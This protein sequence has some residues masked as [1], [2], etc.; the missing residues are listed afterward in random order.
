M[1]SSSYRESMRLAMEQNLR[2][3]A[4]PLVSSGVYG[5]PKDQAL[6]VAVETLSAMAEES[7]MDVLMVL[8]DE[9]GVEL[10]REHYP[11]LV[12]LL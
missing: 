5:Y 1:L 10:A 6:R 12:S 9:E 4:F 3:I 8:F 11:T 7:G 2:R